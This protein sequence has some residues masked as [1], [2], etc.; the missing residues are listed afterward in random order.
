MVNYLGHYFVSGKKFKKEGGQVSMEKEK[1]KA[2]KVVFL[3]RSRMYAGKPLHD[4]T[5]LSV[6]Q[7]RHKVSNAA[8]LPVRDAG[9]ANSGTHDG[10]API[11]GTVLEATVND[12]GELWLKYEVDLGKIRRSDIKLI[13]TGKAAAFAAFGYSK[14]DGGYQDMVYAAIYEA[15]PNRFTGEDDPDFHRVQKGAK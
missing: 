14:I 2:R 4:G 12:A 10:L 3:T 11:V 1:A 6:E 9:Q 7:L 8:G 13:M 5:I 15:E